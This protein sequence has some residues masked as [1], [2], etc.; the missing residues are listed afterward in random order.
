MCYHLYTTCLL[1]SKQLNEEATELRERIKHLNDM[2]FSQ[3]RKVKSMIEE[4]K[5]QC[6]IYIC[7]KSSLDMT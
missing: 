3:Q 5:I 6:T 7:Q 4:V 2:V 1:R